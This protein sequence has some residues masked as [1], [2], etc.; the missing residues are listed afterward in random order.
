[1]NKTVRHRKIFTGLYNDMVEVQESDF[2]LQTIPQSVHQLRPQINNNGM[3]AKTQRLQKQERTQWCDIKKVCT[4]NFE[5]TIENGTNAEE[6]ESSMEDESEIL[7][8]EVISTRRE[9]SG[10]RK[11]WVGR[12][13]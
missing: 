5:Y 6:L 1:M 4:K 13:G 9:I 8:P 11:Q 10:F 12:L 7:I 2:E 3:Q